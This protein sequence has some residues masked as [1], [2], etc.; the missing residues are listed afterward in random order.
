MILKTLMINGDSLQEIFINTN[1]VMYFEF[2]DTFVKLNG[3]VITPKDLGIMLDQFVVA[4]FVNSDRMHLALSHAS[5]SSLK[6]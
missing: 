2:T 1:N 3:T 5:L 6:G 4:T